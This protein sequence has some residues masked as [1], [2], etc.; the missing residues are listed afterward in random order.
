MGAVPDGGIVPDL[1]PRELV[2][3]TPELPV[4]IGAVPGGAVLRGAVPEGGRRPELGAVPTG[5]VPKGG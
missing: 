5:P 3:G 1:V 2:K 4:P